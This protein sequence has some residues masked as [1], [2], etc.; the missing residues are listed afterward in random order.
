[1]LLVG[2]DIQKTTP[3]GAMGLSPETPHE[4]VL[5]AMRA[6]IDGTPD[7]IFVKDAR[8]RHLLVNA[9]GA[10]LVGKPAAE[11]IGKYDA[12]LWPPEMAR[13]IIEAD[14]RILE[15]GTS[16]T[17]EDA[18]L[19][20]GVTRAYEGTRGV[21]RDNFG[22]I[23]GVFGI[24][25]DITE[26]KRVQAALRESEERFKNFID[27]S[28][29]VAFIKE[30]EGKYTYVNKGYERRFGRKPEDVLGRND[31]ELWPADVARTFREADGAVMLA[32][33]MEEFIEKVPDPDGSL[34]YWRVFKFPFCDGI[35]NVLVGGMAVDI[36]GEKQA[37]ET[38]QEYANR[39]K[40]LSGRLLEV[41]EQERRHL[42]RE[43]HDEI[44][45]LLT[46]LRLSLEASARADGELASHFLGDAQGMVKGLS[47]RVRDLSLR[48]R[49]TM[50]DDLG[51]LPA[52][53]WLFDSYTVRTEIAV[54]FKHSGLSRRLGQSVE[55]AAYRIVQEALTN[56]ARHAGV[57][58]VSVSAWT[59][60]EHV[61]LQM[62]DAGLGFDANQ[63]QAASRTTGLSGMQE[64]A[65][66]LGGK[67]V[68]ES[69]PGLGTRIT[70]S[71]PIG[72]AAEGRT[73]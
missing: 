50:L 41:Q 32:G 38:L 7:A 56:V 55:T 66:L 29:A 18:F 51:L 9:A 53:L 61:H 13:A 25:R 57:D 12:E 64:R 14:R 67:L 63:E 40:A 47:A 15:N 4:H 69:S 17:Y 59:E 43:L 39:L 46:G 54:I 10:Q 34:K 21:Y 30:A 35:G 62:E 71:L 31:F 22:K 36:T 28:P 60:D 70:A 6:L 8:G 16:E 49:P 20:D 19:V 27:N 2:N 42:A 45:Q 5:A 26:R 72:D 58:K 52:L 33:A 73:A 24:A 23:L 11:I 1:M 3:A 48:L 68:I 65:A 37:K 44:G